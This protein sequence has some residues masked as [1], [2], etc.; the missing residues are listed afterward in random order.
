[1][2]MGTGSELTDTREHIEKLLRAAFSPVRLTVIDDS[3]AHAGHA[4]ARL[5]PAA[6]HYR[7]MIESDHFA[8]KNRVQCHQLVFQ[9]LGELMQTRI[10]ALSITASAPAN[11]TGS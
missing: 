8:G 1:M 7:V 9:A 4:Q 3:A 6:G 10:H 5:N 11:P 2:T